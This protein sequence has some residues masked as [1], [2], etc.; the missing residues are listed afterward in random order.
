MKGEA[1]TM[2]KLRKK[3]NVIK[4]TLRLVL[5]FTIKVWNNEFL[6]I[7]LAGAPKT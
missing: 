6:D 4:K 5:P 2:T 1:R 3:I 7:M